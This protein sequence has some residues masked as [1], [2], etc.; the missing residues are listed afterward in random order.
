MNRAKKKKKKMLHKIMFSVF[1]NIKFI[2][3]YVLLLSIYFLMYNL[4][5]NFT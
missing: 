5:N 1:L 3:F 4:N 2:N